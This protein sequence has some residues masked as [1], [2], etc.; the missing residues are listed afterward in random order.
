MYIRNNNILHLNNLSY[1]KS[2]VPY[3]VSKLRSKNKRNIYKTLIN[4]EDTSN[5]FNPKW[6]TDLGQQIDAQ[7]YSK[8]F[9][10]CFNTEENNYLKWHQYKILTRILGIKTK[11]YK[12]KIKDDAICR[13]CNN[14]D[15]YF[16]PVSEHLRV[17]GQYID[18]DKK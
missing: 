15:E 3:L 17:M 10:I 5:L 1:T 7:T 4:I 14:Y 18:M 6:E 8:A 11:L 9:N 13:L 16:Y 12:M 2:H